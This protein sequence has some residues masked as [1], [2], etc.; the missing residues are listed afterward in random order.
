MTNQSNSDIVFP[1]KISYWYWKYEKFKSNMFPPNFCAKR[2]S[3]KK[4]TN[5][6]FGYEGFR[7][8]VM[9]ILAMFTMVL[10]TNV[11]LSL[12]N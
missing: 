3:N 10:Q 9:M 6:C 1:L 4:C 7:C 8:F 2:S 11:S 5:M 12:I